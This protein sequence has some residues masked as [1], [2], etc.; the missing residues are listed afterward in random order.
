MSG[1][2]ASKTVV[3]RK[4]CKCWGCAR[5]FPKGTKMDRVTCVDGGEIFAVKWCATC[6]QWLNENDDGEGVEFGF[7]RGEEDWQKLRKELDG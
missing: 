1:T 2:I 5:E 6:Q 7:L 3:T 4:P